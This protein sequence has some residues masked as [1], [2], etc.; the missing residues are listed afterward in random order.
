MLRLAVSFE[1][2]G[3]APGERVVLML[4]NGTEHRLADQA[5]VHAGGVPVTF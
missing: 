1:A 3:L 2:L 4:P 5:A